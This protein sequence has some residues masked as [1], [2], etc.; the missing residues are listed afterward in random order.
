MWRHLKARYNVIRDKGKTKVLRENVADTHFNGENE[1]SHGCRNNYKAFSLMRQIIKLLATINHK[2]W[3]NIMASISLKC[4]I[5]MYSTILINHAKVEE[6]LFNV[7]VLFNL[8]IHQVLRY[9]EAQR[10]YGGVWSH[11]RV[12]HLGSIWRVGNFCLYGYLEKWKYP[13]FRFDFD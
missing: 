8:T 5:N 1:E 4:N 2:T 9:L 11:F 3:W 12:I 10:K 7:A 6:L 13:A